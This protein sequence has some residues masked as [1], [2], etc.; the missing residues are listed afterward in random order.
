MN[1]DMYKSLQRSWA[2]RG[3][4]RAVDK[5]GLF[6]ALIFVLATCF[7]IRA[8]SDKT[9]EQVGNTLQ[10]HLGSLPLKSRSARRAGFLAKQS[11]EGRSMPGLKRELDAR[12]GG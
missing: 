6:V 3:K 12:Q 9:I 5:K 2:S 8:C 4:R 10:K 7:W 1:A 11:F